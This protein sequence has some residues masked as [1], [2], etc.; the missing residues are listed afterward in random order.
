MVELCPN[1]SNKHIYDME[2]LMHCK[3][4]F[5]PPRPKRTISP[6]ANWQQYD[7]T[8]EYCHNNASNVQETINLQVAFENRGQMM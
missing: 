2:Y 1:D 5:E 3:V 7:Y 6:Y 4:V 8:K